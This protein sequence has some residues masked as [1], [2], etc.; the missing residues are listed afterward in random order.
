MFL[1]QLRRNPAPFSWYTAQTNPASGLPERVGRDL[2]RMASERGDFF[3]GEIHDL[4][5]LGPDVGDVRLRPVRRN[6]PPRLRHPHTSATPTP[7]GSQHELQR[8]C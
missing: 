8:A 1:V 2:A 5:R 7:H 6:L 4:D 3:G